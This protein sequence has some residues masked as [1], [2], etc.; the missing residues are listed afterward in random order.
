M[1]TYKVLMHMSNGFGGY[2]DYYIT[3]YRTDSHGDIFSKI[4]HDGLPWRAKIYKTYK[5]ALSAAQKIIEHD[6][7]AIEVEILDNTGNVCE[8]LKKKK[9]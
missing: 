3:G 8:I 7:R 2:G 5:S 9:S 4:V 6:C 1:N